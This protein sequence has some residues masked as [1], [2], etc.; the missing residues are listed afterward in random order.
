MAGKKLNIVALAGSEL[1][2]PI[3]EAMCDFRRSVMKMKP[4]IDL[5]SDFEKFCQFCRRARYVRLLYTPEQRLVGSVV[6]MVDEK[7]SSNG[8]PYT[9][10]QLEYVFLAKE[11]RGHWAFPFAIFRVLLNV[12]LRSIGREVWYCGIGY[13]ASFVFFN[14]FVNN[15]YLSSDMVDGNKVPLIAREILQNLIV[16]QGQ[17]GWDAAR[18][19]AIMPTMPP[20]MSARW[21]AH[22]DTKP[23]Y[24]RYAAHCA[25]WR[26]GFA[27]PGC[28]RLQVLLIIWRSLI[29]IFLRARRR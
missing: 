23:L 27:L 10:L 22:V 14:E 1:T 6:V 26:D 25:D 9:E 29:K 7:T 24:Q 15:G 20:V 13:P 28:A 11:Y 12:L 8:I 21:Q 4:G 3:L 5:A 2:A 18:K 19:V 17:D 16:E